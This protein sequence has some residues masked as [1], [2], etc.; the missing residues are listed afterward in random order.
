[1]VKEFKVFYGTT[2]ATQEQLDAIEEIV[3]EQEVGNAWSARIK[4]PVCIAEDG[5]WDGENDPN[6]AE[7]SRIRVEARIEPG[8]FV[9]LIDGTI[10]DLNRDLNAQPGLSSVTIVVNDDIV[11]LNRAEVPETFPAGTSDSDIATQIFAS[12]G[13]TPTSDVDATE[14]PPDPTAVTNQHGTPMQMLRTLVS[15]NPD[16]NAYVL[17]GEAAGATIGCFKKLPTATDG[18]PEMFLTGDDRNLASFNITQNS[19]RAADYTSDHVSTQDMSVTSGT[20][21]YRDAVPPGGE[22]ATALSE[23]QARAR[24]HTRGSG[25][26]ANPATAATGASLQSSYTLSVEGSVLPQCYA[27]V[28]T[29]Y[30]MVSARLSNSRFSTDYVIYKVTHTLGRSEYTQSFSLRGNM[31]SPEASASAGLPSAAAAVGG[32]AAVSFNIQIDIF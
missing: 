23:A 26:H 16:Y 29:P 18:L 3:V 1:M 14:A 6:H 15:R 8:D 21:S 12:S 11:L 31:A 27:A 24:R 19:S 5:S 25:D 7:G 22:G 2:P 4:I 13:V 17:P 9:P 20:A 28:L 32:A 30:R 10:V